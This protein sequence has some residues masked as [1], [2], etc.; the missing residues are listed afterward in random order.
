MDKGDVCKYSWIKM[1]VNSWCKVKNINI[2]GK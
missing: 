2:Q 1:Y